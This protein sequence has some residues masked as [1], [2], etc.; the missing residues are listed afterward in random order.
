MKHP[1]VSQELPSQ[2]NSSGQKTEELMFSNYQPLWQFELL[3]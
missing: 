2:T 3:S 1:K